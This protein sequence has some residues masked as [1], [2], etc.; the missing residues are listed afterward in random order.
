MVDIVTPPNY[1]GTKITQLKPLPA[2]TDMSKVRVVVVTD[3]GN[4]DMTLAQL[5]AYIKS[6]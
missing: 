1:Q 4:F 3:Q 2:G 5:A 6:M